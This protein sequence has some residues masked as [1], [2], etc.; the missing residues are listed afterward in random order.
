[1]VFGL[2][3]RLK[4][5]WLTECTQEYAENLV[6]LRDELRAFIDKMN[7]GPIMIRLAWH[8]SGTYDVSKPGVG[9]ANG[10]IR[11]KEELGHGANAGLSKALRYVEKFKEKYPMISYAD[12]M[13]MASA[14][15]IELMGGPHINMRYGRIDADECPPE[16]NLPA[17]NSPF[18]GGVDAKQH[19]RDVFHRMGFSDQEV[20]ALSGAHTVGRAFTERSG[21]TKY[22]YGSRGTSYTSN[23][24]HKARR[25]GKEGLGMTGGQSWTKNWLTFDNSYFIR[26]GDE[27]LIVLETDDII[28]K[29]PAFKP[30]AERYAKSKEEFFKDY[31]QAHKR[32][33]ELGSRWMVVD[34]ITIPPS[35]SK[36]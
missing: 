29:D 14:E 6:L 30:H 8:D 19:L 11:F 35:K 7:C 17:G 9:G 34:G 12:I 28:M 36:L 32:L 20:V 27:S 21:T 2:G 1:L 16:G 15:A 23:E 22:G 24:A 10:S 4:D 18:P 13:Q 3:L 25:D 31:A 26:D 33:S 5:A